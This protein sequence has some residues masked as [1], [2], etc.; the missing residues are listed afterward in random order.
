MPQAMVSPETIG[1]EKCGICYR[2][3]GVHLGN[4]PCRNCER[5]H[6]PEHTDH[7]TESE[8]TPELCTECG[9]AYRLNGTE[10]LK[11]VYQR[12]LRT[13]GS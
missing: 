3:F 12:L 7:I 9:E 5:P 2:M 4:E 6:C 8:L 11:A 13:H 1:S 10:G